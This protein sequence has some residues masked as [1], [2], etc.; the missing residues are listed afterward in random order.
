MKNQ[1]YDLYEK[2]MKNGKHL[3]TN[4]RKIDKKR[5]GNI[6]KKVQKGQL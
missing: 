4:T 2:T 1:R 3:R 6:A 5:I